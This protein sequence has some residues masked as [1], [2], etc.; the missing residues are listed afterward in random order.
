MYSSNKLLPWCSCSLV[1]Q[2]K[3]VIMKI[4]FHH[5]IKFHKAPERF[6]NSKLRIVRMKQLW[7]VS[8]RTRMGSSMINCHT[9]STVNL[10]ANHPQPGSIH[11]YNHRHFIRR[12]RPSPYP[13]SRPIYLQG[14]RY[15]YCCRSLALMLLLLMMHDDNDVW[16]LWCHSQW[17]SVKAGDLQSSV[18]TKPF[19]ITNL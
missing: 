11:H 5:I 8:S 1:I 15:E 4:M 14:V 9:I 7:W 16:C 19:S 3:K 12:H 6:F 10:E 2:Y 17:A 18:L 13:C